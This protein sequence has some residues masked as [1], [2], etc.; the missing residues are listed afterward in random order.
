MPH[1][2]KRWSFKGVA[3]AASLMI[4]FAACGNSA[5]SPSA[6][7]SRATTAPSD[8]TSSAAAP[9]AAAFE[10]RLSGDR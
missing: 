2:P 10:G 3:F 4:I 1:T 6:E 8:R 5:S 9:S 7:R